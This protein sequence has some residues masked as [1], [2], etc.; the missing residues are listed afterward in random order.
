MDSHLEKIRDVQK[1][2]WN[3]QSPGWKKWDEMMMTFLK[4]MTVE[5]IHMLRLSD[6]DIVMDVATGTGEPGLTIAS[7]L[8]QGKVTGTDLADSMLAVAAENAVKR[9]IYN[10][11]TVCCDVSALPFED[12]TFTA[13][14]CRL[15]FM[16]FP[17]MQLALKE[18]L[19]VLKPGGRIA[20]S[21]WDI[22]EKNSWMSVSMETMISMLHLNPPAPGATGAYRCAQPGFMADLFRQSGLKNI[23]EKEVVGKFKCDTFETYWSFITDAGSPMAYSKADEALQLQIKKEVFAKVSRRC[24]DGHISLD[25]SAIVIYGE[26]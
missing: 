16:F 5:I 14:S 4:P 18:M 25:S 6:D 13:V 23:S 9:S 24:S 8:K 17:D 21:V 10:F 12:G 3:K 26:K 7:M 19:R 11:E 1:E 15:G 22:P 2:A 20:A